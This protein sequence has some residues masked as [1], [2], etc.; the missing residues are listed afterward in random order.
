MKVAIAITMALIAA[1]SYAFADNVISWV[2]VHT[3][4]MDEYRALTSDTSLDIATAKTGEYVE[5]IIRQD[6]LDALAGEGYGYEYLM[7]DIYDP[8]HYEGKGYSNYTNYG[9]MED[10]LDAIVT[11]YP[12][13]VKRTNE[14]T[15]RQGTHDIFLIKVSDNVG[16]SEP[17]E[18]KLLVTGVHHTREP[19]SLEVPLYFLEQ[20]CADYATDPD[21]QD[22]VNGLELYVIPLLVPEGYNYDDI[23]NERHMWRKN[24]YDWP[25]PY[26]PLDYGGGSGT[27]VDVN[28]NYSYEWGN[29]TGW[30]SQ[31]YCGVAPL[32]EPENQIVADLATNVG[33]VS[34]ISFH[35]H[36]QLILRPWAYT[37]SDP[38]ADDLAVF[39]AIGNGYRDV[40]H[41]ETGIWYT[42]Q[43][44]ADMYTARGVFVDYLYGE[45]GC[46]PYCIELGTSFYPDDSLIP[47]MVTS[48]YEAL[49]WWCLYVLDG[50]TDVDDE[51][52]NPNAPT[53]FALKSA[54]PN[55]ASD[56]ATFAFAL[57]ETA[58]VSLDIYDI[59]GR[60]V[61]NVL[62][63]TV[64]SGENEITADVSGL[65]SGV[66]LYRMTAGDYSAAK[67]MVIR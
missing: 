24:G 35:A 66:Y 33:F 43:G 9:E 44:W 32:S 19:M 36:G 41:D 63:E 45:F 46:Y 30:S 21:V 16:T 40:I 5:L 67:K 54:F 57:P 1:T 64:E 22:I 2:R 61:M 65:S 17:E 29:G 55:P 60:K 8:A 42:Y 62:D 37:Y 51:S 18:D 11:G 7:Y 50:M 6:R 53:T 31:T 47:E 58:Q 28:R 15:G 14:G 49:K 59:K 39:D 38:P 13:I 3:S 26:Q 48:H 56:T 52:G 10:R 34:A 20:L 23:E 12:N 25:D 27:G 4:T